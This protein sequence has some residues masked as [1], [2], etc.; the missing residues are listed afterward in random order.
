MPKQ[1]PLF[2]PKKNNQQAVPN[3]FSARS[4]RK[5]RPVTNGSLSNPL[6]K[7][8]TGAVRIETN[9]K[10][11]NWTPK[12]LAIASILVGAPYLGG[13]IA[14]L[15]AG[16]PFIALILIGLGLLIAILSAILQWLDRAEL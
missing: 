14:S 13:I 9:W 8:G 11:I 6:P 15:W 2:N 3:Q 4:N 7:A 12:K 1:E 16:L 10:S 5:N